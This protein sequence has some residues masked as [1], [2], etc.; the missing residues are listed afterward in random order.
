MQKALSVW[1]SI[2]LLGVATASLNAEVTTTSISGTVSDPSGAVVANA[3]VIVTNV[4][5][6]LTR[7]TKTGS[8]GEY[9]VDQL[10]VGE[11]QV[12]ITSQGFKK[13]VSRGIMLEINV[14][15][16]VD[17]SLGLG[18]ASESVEVVGAA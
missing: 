2:L 5:T 6:G 9:R 15:A 12:E 3:E 7:V 17:A 13:F 8:A 18:A 10:P 14:I 4:G 1:L 11:Y 16:R